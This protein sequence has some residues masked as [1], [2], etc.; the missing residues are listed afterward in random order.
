MTVQP[1]RRCNWRRTDPRLGL[2]QRLGVAAGWWQPIVTGVIGT[3]SS[4]ALRSCDETKYGAAPALRPPWI[5]VPS[6][7]Q[8]CRKAENRYGFP[9]LR[10]PYESVF[11][12]TGRATCRTNCSG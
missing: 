11:E 3:P 12:N 2:R 8:L 9:P 5:D 4:S 7:L 1:S 10:D 6:T